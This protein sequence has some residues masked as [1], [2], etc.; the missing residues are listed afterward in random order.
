MLMLAWMLAQWKRNGR[1]PRDV[2]AVSHR[3]A[4]EYDDFW[5]NDE[6][7][8]KT[9]TFHPVVSFRYTNNKEE[10]DKK[11]LYY[12]KDEYHDFVNNEQLR[13]LNKLIKA[14]RERPVEEASR[15]IIRDDGMMLDDDASKQVVHQGSPPSVAHF[16]IILVPPGKPS[17]CQFL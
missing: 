2:A 13:R 4:K 14:R 5:R 9:V 1:R 10:L 12:S 17:E 8:R 3:R 16:D 11:Q 15:P 7:A 6:A